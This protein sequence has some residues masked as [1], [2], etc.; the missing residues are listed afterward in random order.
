MSDSMAIFETCFK[1]KLSSNIN[2][3]SFLNRYISLIRMLDFIF[4]Y[5]KSKENIIHPFFTK[6]TNVCVS[7]LAIHF[8]YLLYF[9][10]T[11]NHNT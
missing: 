4:F 10:M 11:S 6:R 2:V 5:A 9:F 1:R 7:F 8:L 3:S